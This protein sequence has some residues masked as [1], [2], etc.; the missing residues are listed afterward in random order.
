MDTPFRRVYARS[1]LAREEIALPAQTHR[2]IALYA[3]LLLANV[4][5]WLWARMLF[6][7]EPVLM[8]MATLAYGLGLRH[9]MDA[10]HIAAIDNVTRQL[11]HN[12]E[13]PITV[14]FYFSLGHSTVVM[15]VC[16]ALAETAIHLRGSFAVMSSVGG[17]V[18]GSISVTL[19][20]VL[21]F[22]NFS[23]LRSSWP[24][25]RNHGE[26]QASERG[27][28]LS[29]ILRPL[30]SLVHHPW[31]AYPLGFLFGLGFD[32]ATEVGLLGVSV[33]ASHRISPWAIMVFPTLFA[34]GMVLIDTTQGV[35]ANGAYGFASIGRR[36]KVYNFVIGL[37][38]AMAALTVGSLEA[39]NLIG[40]RFA[41]T[42]AFW[43][44]VSDLNDRT[45]ALGYLITGVLLSLWLFFALRSRLKWL[46]G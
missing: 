36:H 31:Q 29:R 34:G 25:R 41:L 16:A 35:L 12:G 43:Q 15:L 2:L 20:L 39:L 21:A 10:D 32:T 27:G 4:C 38:S 28:I 40:E 6:W 13:K 26:A 5:A 44:R 37:Y 30:T 11:L 23:T 7:H 14:G 19:L 42:G 46:A 9:A 33:S 18:G 22:A 24:V 1:E 45:V 3:L 17:L 8:G